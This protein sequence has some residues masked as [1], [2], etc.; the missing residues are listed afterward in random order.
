V[1]CIAV[2]LTVLAILTGPTAH[3]QVP[4]G[5]TTAIMPSPL[6]IVLTVGKWIWDGSTREQVYY[7]EVSSDGRT[8]TEAR[9]NG[10]RLAAESALGSVITSETEV[11]NGRVVRDEIISYAAGFVERFEIV[12]TTA[13]PSGYTVVMKVWI[14]RSAL[15]NRLL[16]RSEQSGQVNGA[17]ASVQLQT[18]NQERATGDRLLQQVLNDFPRRAFDIE[19]KPADILRQNRVA[20]M[21]LSFKLGWNQD[22]LRSLWIAL[23]A[24]AQRTN[25]PATTIIVNGGGWFSGIGGAAKF[26]DDH[27]LNLLINHMYVSGPAVLVTVRGSSRE[28]LF[29]A[30]YMYQELDNMAQYAVTTQRLVE[31]GAG[32]ARINGSYRLNGQVQIPINNAVLPQATSVDVDV[33]PRK[34]CPNR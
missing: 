27:K 10:F 25:R 5:V 33:V 18:L 30:C 15:A 1:R 16:N 31:F 26:D 22:Y 9:N 11:Q 20:Y 12:N 4:V 29:S 19:M 23:E 7:I 2:V 8:V 24:T 34:N 6:G 17:Q 14:R 3:A 32:Y 21:E 13:V 28:T